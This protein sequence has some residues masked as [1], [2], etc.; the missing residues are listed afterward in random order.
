MLKLLLTGDWHVGQSFPRFAPDAA[1]RLTQAR[2]EV[3][4]RIFHEA[5]VNQVDAVLCAGDLFDGPKPNRELREA[6]AAKL[7]ALPWRERQVILLPGTH[8]RLSA[9]SVWKDPAFRRALPKFVTVVDEPRL[10]M[11]LK[12]NCVL[13][14]GSGIPR[15]EVGDARARVGLVH[16]SAPTDDWTRELGLDVLAVGGSHG[17]QVTPAH[18]GGTTV[19]SPGTPEPTDFEER[20]AGQVAVVVIKPTGEVVVHPQRVAAWTWD[21]STVT[22]M[23][24]LRSLLSRTDWANRVLR[25]VLDLRVDPKA[26]GEIEGAL[27]R[28]QGSETQAGMAHVLEVDRERLGLD[29]AT[30]EQAIES[31]PG[32]LRVAAGTLKRTAETAEL[33]NERAAA[34]RALVH[35]FALAGGE[36]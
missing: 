36:D 32:A 27:L 29:K 28:L 30:V 15:R 26:L 2:V 14:A 10:E 11:E 16:R 4:D 13:Y 9:D 17:L 23:A 31:L 22:S 7:A 21:V 25:L 1:A 34:E 18:A 3:L 5:E 19:V 12:P 33:P 35:L 6:L 20:D 24:G 8:D